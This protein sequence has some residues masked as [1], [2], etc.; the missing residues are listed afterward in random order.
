MPMDPQAQ[1]YLERVAALGIPP[2]QTL[3]PQENR[4]ERARLLDLR[5]AL[6]GPRTPETVASVE[7]RRIPVPG[8]DVGV[9]LYIPAGTGPLPVLVYFFGGGFIMG[10]IDSV[11][12]ACRMMANR[13]GCIVASA[14]YRL[15]PEHKFP[16]SVEDGYAAVTWVAEQAASFQGDPTRLAVGGESAGG[17]VAAVVCLLARAR[18]G[19]R[20]ALQVLIYPPVDFTARRSVDQEIAGRATLTDERMAYFD[21]HY[22]RTSDDARDPLAS[23]MLADDVRGLPAAVVIGAEYDPLAA[24]G[25]AY[26]EKLRQAGVRAT[27]TC[28]PGMIHGFYSMPGIFTQAGHAIEQVAAE[29]RAAFN[30][31]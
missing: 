14:E 30:T 5:R 2:V 9:R 25:A 26:A 23:P 22:F 24:E 8:G 15:A 31:R 17:N 10:D 20:L 11:D 7:D 12:E 21:R 1:A 16:G 28:Y 27:D 6:A 18:G 13:A 29:L 4:R 3:T 19:P